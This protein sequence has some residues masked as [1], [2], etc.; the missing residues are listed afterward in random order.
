[1]G[2]K[3]NLVVIG[4]GMSGARTVEEILARGG[5]E[6]FNIAMF[7]GEPFGNY[8]RILL[9]AVL[10][11]SQ[12]A[13]EISLNPLVWYEQHGIRL[14]AGVRATRIFRFARRVLGADG[15][16]EP[17]DNLVIATGSRSFIPPL[18]GLTQSDGSMKP[19]IFGFRSLDDCRRMADY[20]SGKKR[21]AVVGGGLLGLECAHGLQSFGLEVHVIHRSPHLMNQQLD[22]AAGA[23]L[24]SLMEEMGILVHLGA[25]TRR[26][27]GDERVSGLEFSNGE[28]LECD[29]VVFAT[30]IKPNSE[31]ASQAG[32]TV[33]RAIV[34]DNQMRTDDS[35][36]YA[37]GECV[38]HRGQTYG[39]VAPIWEQVKVLADQITGANSKAAYHGSKVATRLKVAGVELASMGLTEP[40]EQ[41]DEVVQFTEP[42]RGTYKKLIIRDGR[43]MGG[44]LLGDS[45]RAAS[46]QHAF[47]SSAPLPAERINLLFDIGASPKRVT[48]AEIPLDVQIC[49][50]HAVS[51]GA[52]V[53]CVK[54]GR[55]TI[56][57]VR[58]TTRA[59]LA[60]GSC[61]AMVREI[62]EW[63]CGAQNGSSGESAEEVLP[64]SEGEHELQ[65]KYGKSFL[66]LA[67]YKHRVLD[68]LNSAMQEFITRQEMMF[69]G[70]AD[71]NG[72]AD[73]SF[74]AGHPNFVKVL[75]ERTLAYPE[76]RGNGV[77]SSMGNISENP[78]VGLM[79]IDFAKD[80]IGLHVNGSARIVEHDEFVKLM[81]DRSAADVVLGD[82]ALANLISK[83]PGN[84]ERWVI[85]SVDEAYMHCSKHIPLMRKIEQEVQWG[86]DDVR[87]KGGDYFE[88]DKVPK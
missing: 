60:C 38:Q 32:L 5:A 3:R 71:R 46:L 47:E 77:M 64:G 17:Y 25:D 51:K 30:G 81:R 66:A 39:L 36:I 13:A 48:L 79:F 84:L 67:F 12:A 88:A 27:L 87:A 28:T 10:D 31:I 80:R 78:H 50:C 85:V 11:G 41:R 72:N 55:R 40:G 15:S 23:I 52:L 82:S 69:V 59:G 58:E 75:D 34:V 76:F 33:E 68:H 1:M 65:Q 26:V 4:N 22:S 44:I 74:R 16:E 19:G 37:V 86:T 21:A 42:R 6:Q 83:D 9:S 7:G 54:N 49:S 43:L 53:E 2:A 29:L 70:T 20:A 63:A 35:R 56:E 14:H 61:E 45:R 73:S 8:N 18:P 57:A 24:K 62:V